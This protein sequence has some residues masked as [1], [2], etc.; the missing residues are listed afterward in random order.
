M[1]GTVQDL[2]VQQQA[3]LRALGLPRPGDALAA[4]QGVLV[5]DALHERGLRAYRSNGRALAQRALAAAYPVVAQ[6]LGDENFGPVARQLWQDHPPVRG[7]LAQ[8]GAALPGWIARQPQLHAAEPYLADVARLEWALHQAA[9]AA[10]AAIDAAS[11]G[12]LQA[13]DP[14]HLSLRC[15]PGSAVIAAPWPIASIVL[16]HTQGQPSIEAA[17]DRLRAGLAETALVWRQGLQP[18]LRTLAADEAALLVAL[19]AGRPL[20]AALDAAPGLDFAPWLAA[21]VQQGL[22][23]GAALLRDERGATP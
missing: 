16:A 6:L 3:L 11:F 21:A 2:A 15:A 14:A 18:R 13:H 10:D 20:A 7:D 19:L 4:V 8:W 5:R 12:L 9:S 23:T 17:G 22:V 1:S